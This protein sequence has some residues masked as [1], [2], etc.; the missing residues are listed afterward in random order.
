MFVSLEFSNDILKRV[1]LWGITFQ[2][3]AKI[4]NIVYLSF[5]HFIKADTN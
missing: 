1:G 4:V 2:G 3:F 5:S